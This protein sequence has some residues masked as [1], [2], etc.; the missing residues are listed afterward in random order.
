MIKVARAVQHAH[1]GGILHRDLKPANILL[2]DAGDPI[3]TDFGLAVDIMLASASAPEAQGHSDSASRSY[4]GIVGTASFMSPEQAH[5]PSAPTIQSDV[6]GLGAV[7]YAMLTG[8]PPFL[9]ID[10]AD[11]LRLVR[12]PHRAP[13]LPRSL[14][15][16]VDLDLQAICMKCLN[17]N[18]AARY[19]SAEELASD[20]QRW[21]DSRETVACPWSR[22]YRLWRWCKRNPLVM[23]MGMAA[24]ALLAMMDIGNAFALLSE[25][26]AQALSSNGNTARS[27]AN[28]VR[29]WLQ[30]YTHAAARGQ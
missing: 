26:E 15:P 18:K 22:P 1:Q 2:E 29:T 19:V 24:I 8:R 7:L 10:L 28:T 9:G 5:S 12:D 4:Q 21:L 14:N 25:R 11:T 13:V 17:K 23:G 6:Y 16:R 30:H 20:L 27:V 3:V